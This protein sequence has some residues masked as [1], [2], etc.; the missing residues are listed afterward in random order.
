MFRGREDRLGGGGHQLLGWGLD[1]E[2]DVEVY[3]REPGPEDR[4]R[5]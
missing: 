2:H 5:R 4:G 3:H 1:R